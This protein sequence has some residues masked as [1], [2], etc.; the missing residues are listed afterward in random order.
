MNYCPICGRLSFDFDPRFGAYRC[1]SLECLFID[2]EKIHGEG[3]SE[4]PD[5]SLLSEKPTIEDFKKRKKEE[6]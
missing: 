4:R 6:L 1:F 2:Y 5:S 3:F